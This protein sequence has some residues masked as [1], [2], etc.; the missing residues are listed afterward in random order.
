MSLDEQSMCCDSWCA[1]V[2]ARTSS[3]RRRQRSV[4]IS[5]LS[6]P[7][8]LNHT[9]GTVAFML[10]EAAAGSLS[11]GEVF[12]AV[13]N[14]ICPVL[15]IIGIW[16]YIKNKISPPSAPPG[17]SSCY[18]CRGTGIDPATSTYGQTCRKCGGR[19]W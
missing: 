9:L 4:L 2:V 14:L 10:A 11:W 13:G 15:F 16:R 3:A 19:R 7:F 5:G 17:A 8:Q 6:G 18:Y 12:T 1:I